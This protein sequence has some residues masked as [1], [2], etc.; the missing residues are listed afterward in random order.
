MFNLLRGP[1]GSNQSRH[2]DDFGAKKRNFDDLVAKKLS[3]G[4]LFGKNK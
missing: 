3:P 2:V 1:F 4:Q